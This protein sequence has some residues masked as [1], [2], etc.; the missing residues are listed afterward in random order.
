[1]AASSRKI[2]ESNIV[3]LNWV[4]E[5]LKKS[6]ETAASQTNNSAALQLS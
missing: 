1:M 6:L 4:N 2:L 5:N 3:E